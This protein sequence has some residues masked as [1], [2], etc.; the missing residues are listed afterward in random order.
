MGPAQANRDVERFKWR[1]IKMINIKIKIKIAGCV[2]FSAIAY[3]GGFGIH[4]R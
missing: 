1:G 3:D 2:L 4:S